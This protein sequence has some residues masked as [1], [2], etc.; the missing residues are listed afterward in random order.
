MTTVVGA[1]GAGAPGVLTVTCVGAAPT[2]WE[3]AYQ[4]K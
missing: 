1:E 4:K 3:G 2:V